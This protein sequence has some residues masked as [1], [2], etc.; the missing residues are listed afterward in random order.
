M[1]IAATAA[2]ACLHLL[3]DGKLYKM[4]IVTDAAAAAADV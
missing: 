1:H 3:I 4:F 2:A